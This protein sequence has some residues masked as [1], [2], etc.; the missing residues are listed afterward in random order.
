[1]SEPLSVETVRKVAQLSRLHVEQPEAE[2]YARQLGEILGYVNLLNEVNTDDVEP[3]AHAAELTNV[4]R[5]DDPRPSLD[6]D[7]ALAN[8]P[9]SDGRYF[10]VP[11]ILENG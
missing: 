3:M 8:A 11:P 7:A 10:L 2:R 1:M 5:A 4:L 9:H 6:R